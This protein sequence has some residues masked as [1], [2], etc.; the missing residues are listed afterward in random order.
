MPTKLR[1]LHGLPIATTLGPPRRAEVEHWDEHEA[2]KG[3][4]PPNPLSFLFTNLRSRAH[5][6]SLMLGHHPATVWLAWRKRHTR[7]ESSEAL[8]EQPAVGAH[9]GG[10]AWMLR[11][12]VACC[13]APLRQH[14]NG[15]ARASSAG[16]ESGSSSRSLVLHTVSAAARLQ[17]R[18]VEGS[19]T[20]RRRSAL[21]NR[22]RR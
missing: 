14:I 6:S 7:F 18:T 2:V 22:R 20:A 12:G 1:V 5:T 8:A 16:T 4:F 13:G 11:Q 19:A 3:V 9:S 10:A 15:V 17:M 21:G